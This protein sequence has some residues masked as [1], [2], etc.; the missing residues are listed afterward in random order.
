MVW[1]YEIRDGEWC[2][3][4]LDDTR[5]RVVAQMAQNLTPETARQICE[6]FALCS[7]QNIRE[8]LDRAEGAEVRLAYLQS[9]L[10]RLG[11]GE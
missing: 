7:P 1:D 11:G 3:T 2:I 10:R 6:Y 9:E 8:L 5:V 4:V